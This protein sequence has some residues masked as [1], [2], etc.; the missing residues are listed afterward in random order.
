MKGAETEIERQ[1]VRERILTTAAR[2]VLEG[3]VAALTTRAVATAASVQ[4]PTLYRL[5]GNKRGLLDAV[6]ERGLADWV[7]TK[8]A[9][10][11]HPDPV[12]DLRRSWEAF[13]D[14]GLANPAVF[15]IMNDVRDG[16]PPS[17]ATQAGIA[18]LRGRVARL[19]RVGRLCVPEERAVAL[20]HAVGTGTV[21]TLLAAPPDKRDPEL[22]QLAYAGVEAVLLGTRSVAEGSPAGMA[23]GLRANLDAADQLSPGER[24]L[25]SELL[26]RLSTT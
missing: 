14:F 3:G 19:A 4:A 20:I 9:A 6:A 17:P 10:E 24:L 13:I 23:I 12:E 16:R 18:V 5:F 8:S 2:L 7:A 15:A 1:D 25:L 22:A 26:S 11:P 21:Q